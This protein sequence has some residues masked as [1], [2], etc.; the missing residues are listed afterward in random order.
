VLD[1][2]ILLHRASHLAAMIYIQIQM[3]T[4]LAS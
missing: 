1:V 2:V 3:L 4:K